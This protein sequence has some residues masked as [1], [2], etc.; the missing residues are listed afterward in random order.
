MTRTGAIDLGK[1]RCRLAVGEGDARVLV[2]GRGS[3]GLAAADGVDHA[4]AAIL[5]LLEGTDPT[6]LGVG[7]AGAL[8]AADRAAELARRLAAA[9]GIPVAVA[10]DVVTAHAGALHGGPG[11]LLLAGTGAVAFGL[12]EEGHR[13]ADGWGPELGDFGSGSWIG[14]E[15]VRAVLR[16]GVGLGAP[17]RL[18]ADLAAVF[19]DRSPVAWLADGDAPVG[20]RLGTVAPF[21]LDAAAD[22]D[23]AAVGIVDEAVRLLGASASAA[24]ADGGPLALHG[25][26]TSHPFFHARLVDEVVAR[27]FVLVPSP[28][29]ALDGAALI[30]ARRAP[31][32]ERYVH[33]A[34]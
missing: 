8:F 12:D 3:P 24:A 19:G 31:L 18:T 29:D 27:G 7:A 9:C 6:A 25:G 11:V 30:A 22:G 33:R 2:D 10:S 14:R 20:Q 32:H 34:G 16:A 23:P 28:G 26:L 15:G 5:P 4:L 17:T 21:V 1:T 13:L